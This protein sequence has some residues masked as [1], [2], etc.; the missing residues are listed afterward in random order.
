MIEEFQDPAQPRSAGSVRRFGSAIGLVLV[1]LIPALIFGALAIAAPPQ[2]RFVMENAALRGR[3]I[4]NAVPPLFLFATLT[5]LALRA[6]RRLTPLTGAAVALGPAVAL[7]TAVFQGGLTITAIAALALVIAGLFGAYFAF[8][9]IGPTVKPAWIM[10]SWAVLGLTTA[11]F[12]SA[13]LASSFDPINLPRSVGTFAILAL[14]V[15]I[16]G[17]VMC[18]AALRP[19]FA[20]GLLAYM[21]VAGLF[22]GSNEHGVPDVKSKALPQPFDMRLG[23]WIAARK[24]LD[25]YRSRG[26]PYPVVFVSSE[27]GGIYA[28]AHA[29]GVLGSLANHCPTFSQHVFAMVGVSGGAFGNALFAGATNPAQQAYERCRSQAQPVQPGPLGLDHLSPVVARLLLIEPIDRLLPG[30]WSKADR[31]QILTD[32]FLADSPGKDF[33]QRPIGETLDP[34]SARPAIL[35]VAVDVASGRRLVMSPF[36]PSQF[37]GT[38]IWWPV[39]EDMENT[40]N[41]KQISLLSAASLSARFPWVTPTGRLPTA[42]DGE[43]VLADGGYFDNSGADTVLDLVN[44]LRSKEA[45]RK[46][47]LSDNPQENAMAARQCGPNGFRMVINF[48]EK[49]DWDDCVPIFIIHL[50]LASSNSETKTALHPAQ[51]FLLDPI[52]A[53]MATRESRAEIALQRAD[54]D[55]CGTRI[56]GAECYAQPGAS[57]GFFRND[58]A[59]RDWNL[60]L[61][62]FMAS[63]QFY[64]MTDQAI[65]KKLF[66]YRH[67]KQEAT[68][69]LELL[70]FHLDPELYDEG[71]E[72]ILDDLFPDP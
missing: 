21:I 22:F 44:D 4:F 23:R 8:Q 63:E 48:H 52:K 2:Y 58:I 34:N 13:A 35:S 69:D 33:V 67:L 25:A 27:G 49:T 9:R 40:A 39:S 62:W 5:L 3:P 29:Y 10:S 56:P 45:W 14:F 59:P 20:M 42:A 70:I 32:S 65:P 15:G 61:G 54:V 47:P 68:N 60:P 71:S 57:L 18:V 24:D 41:V 7:G 53:L 46:A 36:Y 51:S 30:R 28:A 16:V 31:A 64:S 72:E 38:G 66:N 26:L 1:L 19:P 43:L 37:G 17:V 11:L 50:A 6:H 12:I 55:L